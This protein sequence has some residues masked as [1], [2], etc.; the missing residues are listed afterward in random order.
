MKLDEII[1]EI[2]L[3]AKQG[4]KTKD[5]EFKQKFNEWLEK[6]YRIQF[7]GYFGGEDIL[8]GY[9]GQIGLG[10]LEIFKKRKELERIAKEHHFV[11]Y[12]DFP[13][14]EIRLLNR[15]EVTMILSNELVLIKEKYAIQEN[16]SKAFKEIIEK[17]YNAR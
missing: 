3:A 17:V 2:G 4:R 8:I 11:V 16:A 10:G 12:T 1:K 15:T 5:Q 14:R 13:A 9:V 6:R 7:G